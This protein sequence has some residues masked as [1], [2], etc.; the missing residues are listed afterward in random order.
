MDDLWL[1][2]VK[3]KT[4]PDKQKNEMLKRHKK[5]ADVIVSEVKDVLSEANKDGL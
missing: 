1:D 5:Q 3:L 4:A 2:Y